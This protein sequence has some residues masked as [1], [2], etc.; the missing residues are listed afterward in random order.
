MDKVDYSMLWLILASESQCY[1]IALKIGG[2]MGRTQH[3]PNRWVS[4]VRAR[5]GRLRVRVSA[6]VKGVL[7]SLHVSGD[8][9]LIMG[10]AGKMLTYCKWG[11]GNDEIMICVMSCTVGL[12]SNIIR[13]HLR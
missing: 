12:G 1:R 5:Q 2:Q 9:V 7:Q 11:F 10:G 6:H 3:E 8:I 4:V 13:I